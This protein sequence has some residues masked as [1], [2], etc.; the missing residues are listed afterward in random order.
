MSGPVAVQ[1]RGV[2]ATL[3]ADDL[4]ER[5]RRAL[6]LSAPSEPRPVSWAVDLDGTA[7]SPKWLVGVCFGLR[8][9]AFGTSDALHVLAMVGIPVRRIGS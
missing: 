1:I 3:T 8:R 9:G 6:A 5:G 2:R 7:V 4:L